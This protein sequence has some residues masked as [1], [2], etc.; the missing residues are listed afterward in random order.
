[1]K[2]CYSTENVKCQS[3]LDCCRLAYDYNFDGFEISDAAGERRRHADSIL[4]TELAPDAKRKLINRRLEVAALTCPLP[5]E[6][7]QLTDMILLQYVDMAKNAGIER[8]ILRMENET[9]P[10]VAE[11]KLAAAIKQAERCGIEILFETTGYLAK[12]QNAVDLIKY[13]SS[14]CLGVAWNIRATYFDGGESAAEGI[15]ILGAYIRYVRIGDRAD[16]SDVL[17]GEGTLPVESFLNALKSLNYEGFV[18]ADWND[19]IRDPDIVLT[20]F[21]SFMKGQASRREHQRKLYYNRSR[22]GSFPWKKYDVLDMTFGQLLE[23]MAEFYPDQT[24]F[25][26]TTLDYTRS[27]AQFQK[28][29]DQVAAAFIALGVKPGYHLSLIHI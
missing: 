2:L 10:A 12:T 24:A 19:E 1:M 7:P 3:F 28:D 9:D 15:R 8:V 26:Y 27:Y 14:T 18:C 25:R 4:R 21:E 20:H 17:L 5:L 11:A 22:S 29:V 23:S 16:G 13:F 6:S